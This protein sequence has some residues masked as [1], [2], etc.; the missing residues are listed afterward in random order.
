MKVSLKCEIHGEYSISGRSYLKGTRC[1]KCS[2]ENRAKK[3]YLK[4][5]HTLENRILKIHKGNYLPLPELSGLSSLSDKA[6][7]TCNIHG[8]FETNAMSLL[9]GRGCPSCGRERTN[10][11]IANSKVKTYSQVKAHI[12]KFNIQVEDILES[13]N[14]RILSTS[15]LNLR[16]LKHGEFKRE[17][18]QAMSRKSPCVK[19]SQEESAKKRR[20]TYEDM[21]EQLV[22]SSNGEGYTFPNLQHELL[23]THS[24]ITICCPVHGEY[25]AIFND[26]VAGKHNC[27][28]CGNR[29]SRGE[30][31]IVDYIKSLIGGKEEILESVKPFKNSSLEVDILIPSLK[32]GIEYN[33]CYWHSFPKKNKSYHKDKSKMAE[34]AGYRLLH[35]WDDEWNIDRDK[36]KD[37]LKT[38]L[39]KNEIKEFAR[40]CKIDMISPSEASAFLHKNHLQGPSALSKENISL[41]NSD[42][43]IVALGVF[44]KGFTKNWEL[45]RFA[46]LRGRTIVGGFSKIIN[47]WQK[48][49]PG[50]NLLS[51][52][53]KDKFSGNSYMK[54][55]FE[56]VS[57]SL[58]LSYLYKNVRHSRHRFKK[59]RLKYLPGF[60]PNKTELEICIENG[61]FP[62]YNSGTD[63]LV[64]K[65]KNNT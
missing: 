17:V 21:L 24:E 32:I 33:G 1:E 40:N 34:D 47:F 3:K 2:Y 13:E 11:A 36:I 6:N 46:S 44:R 12:E 27:P 54:I 26:Y 50:E 53:D 43:E 58:M 64:L 8:P 25:K 30:L 59:D 18:K 4:S 61:I 31:E 5:L 52:V 48:R 7:Y 62:V 16:C 9:S 22:G 35:I 20:R 51:Y 14:D 10:T 23:H 45:A 28:K 19:C 63:T 15:I 49:N 41:R 42:G 37:Y 60:D 65:S 57:E 39:G 56:K 38:Q 29:V 55:G